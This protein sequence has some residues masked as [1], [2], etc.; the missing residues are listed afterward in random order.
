MSFIDERKALTREKRIS[1]LSH[2]NGTLETLADEVKGAE[3]KQRI[4]TFSQ[5]SE[6]EVL[7][8]LRVL[9]KIEKVAVIVHGGAG[10][11]A[12]GIYFNEEKNNSWYTTGLNEKD[13]ILGGDKS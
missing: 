1:T 7:N 4:R 12:S 13:T 3:I 9:T 5:A 6:D 2:Y 11:A 8:A 10:C